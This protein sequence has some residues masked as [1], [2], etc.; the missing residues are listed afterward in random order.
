MAG[1]AV[2]AVDEA[3]VAVAADEVAA[4]ATNHPL[5]CRSRREEAHFNAECGT[6]NAEQEI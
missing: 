2:A 1:V 3:A 4:V 5:K 6:R